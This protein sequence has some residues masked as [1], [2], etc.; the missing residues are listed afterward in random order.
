MFESSTVP[1]GHDFVLFL[2]PNVRRD[3]QTFR[4]KFLKKSTSTNFSCITIIS[5]FNDTS[6][7]ARAAL[8]YTYLAKTSGEIWTN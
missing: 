4:V 5:C 3:E 7:N 1:V 8:Y 6:E 2:I